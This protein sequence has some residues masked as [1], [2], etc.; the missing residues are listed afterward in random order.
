MNYTK[1]ND[2]YNFQVWSTKP[3]DTQKLVGDV[4]ENLQAFIPVNQTE[5]QKVPETY[6]SKISREKAELVVQLRSTEE[7]LNCRSFYGRIIF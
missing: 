2:V 4:L 1:F 3:D 6:A 5:V 7:G